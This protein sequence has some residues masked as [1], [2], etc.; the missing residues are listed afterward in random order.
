MMKGKMINWMRWLSIF[1]IVTLPYASTAQGWEKIIPAEDFS[2]LFQGLVKPDSNYYIPVLVDG[3][4]RLVHFDHNGQVLA[5]PALSQE[6][7]FS[8][9]MII[10]ND[11]NFICTRNHGSFI[12]DSTDIGFTK[13]DETG[14]IIWQHTAG[15]SQWYHR[16][17]ALLQDTNGDYVFVGSIGNPGPVMGFI[18]KM[19]ESGN[20]LWLDTIPGSGLVSDYRAAEATDGGYLVA[21]DYFTNTDTLTMIAKYHQDGSLEWSNTDYTLW[22]V[23]AVA[24]LSDGG[25]AVLGG[26]EDGFVVVRL[27]SDGTEEEIIPLPD[28]YP[29]DMV[30]TDDGGIA[31]VIDG[32]L[33]SPDFMINLVKFDADNNE[34]WLRSYVVYPGNN[35]MAGN[36]LE[37]T[38]DGGF[39]IAGVTSGVSDIPEAIE[40]YIIKTDANGYSLTSVINGQVRYDLDEDC[41][42]DANEIPL[43]DWIVTAVG[44]DRN[45]YGIVDA[46]GNYA[47]RVDTGDYAM[48]VS[49]PN[50]YWQPCNDMMP[51]QVAQLWDTMAVDMPISSIIDC[52][53]MEVYTSAMPFRLCDT[54]LMAVYYCND[55]TTLAPDASVV[56]DFDFG[57][58]VV[59]A[60]VPILNQTGSIY[61]F[62]IG[63]VDFLECGSFTIDLGISCDIGFFGQT[64]CTETLIFPDTNC[65]PP[66]PL[67]SGASV[68]V[69]A[70]CEDNEVK[71]SLH[72]IGGGNMQAPL[73]YI[74]IEDDVIMMSDP[75]QLDSGDSTL[76]TLPANGSFYRIESPQVPYHPGSSMPSAQIEA[77]GL[78]DDGSISTGFAVQ[79]PQDDADYNVDILCQEVV[80]AYDPNQKQARPLGYQAPHYIEANTMLD[81]TIQFQNTGTDTARKVVIQDILSPHLDPATF[82][83]GA[84]S[85]A[86]EVAVEGQ[87]VLTFTFDNIMLPDSNIN[88]PASHG[89]VQFSIAQQKDLPSGTIIENTASIFFDFNPPIITNTVY[90][91]IGKDFIIVDIGEVLQS[92]VGVNVY[93]NPFSRRAVF[94]VEG[95]VDKPLNFQL[96]NSVGQ[97]IK[98]AS[99]SDN[100]Y[101]LE[102]DGLQSGIYFYIIKHKEEVL[103]QGKLIMH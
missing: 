8:Q 39:L 72:N 32:A 103:N 43:E 59:G 36:D 53:L 41:E 34:E 51:V 9:L 15:T 85:H 5:A 93:P 4:Y 67:W 68:D 63:D 100:Q 96:F 1:I 98:E 30:A 37:V 49:V 27:N 86:Y 87:G 28:G 61:T 54:I 17:T 18:G 6:E 16:A 90:H 46:N 57:L 77:C 81:Y 97:L 101:L 80:A 20:T 84:S 70:R 22:I 95:L 11:G 88:E 14:N 89:F 73:Q 74:V 21:G 13:F 62:D 66:D 83:R 29:R 60:S 3:D 40:G 102:R 99:F 24:G 71:L 7:L 92:D 91:T 82:H 65:I 33:T 79:Y 75:Y 38:P 42:V 64:L 78:N 58:E 44:A 56:I 35:Y 94:E 12:A 26:T 52:P 23:N 69:G 10:S 76:I 19:D 25:L 50:D 47:I 48:T 2:I 55:G 45:Y 31:V